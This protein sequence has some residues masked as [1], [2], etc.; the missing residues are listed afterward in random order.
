MNTTHGITEPNS[1]Q[2]PLITECTSTIF[3]VLRVEIFSLIEGEWALWVLRFFIDQNKDEPG[4]LKRATYSAHE[5]ETLTCQSPIKGVHSWMLCEQ[6][7]RQG[8]R[9]HRGA[10]VLCDSV[11]IFG[12]LMLRFWGCSVAGF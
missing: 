9:A 2:Y 11:L 12:D 5:P 10:L 6:K 1:I 3:R 7:L 4:F 8:F